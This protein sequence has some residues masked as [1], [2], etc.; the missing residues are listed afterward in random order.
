MMATLEGAENCINISLTSVEYLPNMLLVPLH[1][2]S[3]DYALNPLFLHMT[4]GNGIR[5]IVCF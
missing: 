5:I 2:H 3:V 1:F 4:D